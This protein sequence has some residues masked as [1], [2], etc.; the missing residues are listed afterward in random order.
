MPHTQDDH[1]PAICFSIPDLPAASSACSAAELAAHHSWLSKI[2]KISCG[3]AASKRI[4]AVLVQ[5]KKNTE[6]Y[7][8]NKSNVSTFFCTLS[9]QKVTFIDL[10]VRWRL[11]SGHVDYSSTQLNVQMYN[12]T[13]V[14]Y[15]TALRWMLLRYC[16]VRRKRGSRSR[17][18]FPSQ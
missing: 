12:V 2:H 14:L 7:H 15:S 11:H 18:D 10:R 16:T 13:S 1:D 3:H 6:T 8:R 5:A 9:T 17:A 4:H